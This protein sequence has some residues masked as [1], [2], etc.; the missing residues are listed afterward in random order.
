MPPFR[1]AAVL[2]VFVLMSPAL[3]AAAAERDVVLDGDRF[4]IGSPCADHV[5]IR[6]DPALHGHVAVHASAEH[7][8]EIEQLSI[9]NPDGPAVHRQA[10]RC[11]TPLP[12]ARFRPTLVLQVRVPTGIPLRI[13]EDGRGS[14]LIG[15]VDGP[16]SVA[17]SGDTTLRAEQTTRLDLSLS[18]QASVV[19]T[20]AAGPLDVS[21]S[22]EGGVT[23]AQAEAPSLKAVLSGDGRIVV[24][25]GHADRA[26]LVVSGHGEVRMDATAGDADATVSGVGSVRLAHVTGAL[27]RHVSGI[28]DVTVGGPAG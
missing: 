27:H 21:L 16:L 20:R 3:G 25:A 28:G 9:D 19:V 11:W 18:G 13:E 4:S 24:G 15:P 6:P 12:E 17:A 8:E 1:P 10:D 5:E 22:G 7:R 14:Y 26:T 2:A 23:V